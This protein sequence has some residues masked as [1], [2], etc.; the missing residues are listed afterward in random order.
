MNH[1]VAKQVAFIE[2]E[3]EDAAGGAMAMLQGY[4]FKEADGETTALKIAYAKK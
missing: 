1:I 2:F 4:A 3:T